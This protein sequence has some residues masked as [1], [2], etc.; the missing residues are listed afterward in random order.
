[1]VRTP[2][3]WFLVFEERDV[4]PALF[5]TQDKTAGVLALRFGDA[6]RRLYAGE[7]DFDEATRILRDINE[8]FLNQKGAVGERYRVTQELD[9]SKFA[10][11]PSRK[12]RHAAK[13][14]QEPSAVIREAHS[15]VAFGATPK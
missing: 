10:V 2:F 15:T 7:E 12:L 13:H 4:Y 1:M 8:A 11:R 5:L 9:R 6:V 14:H 3:L